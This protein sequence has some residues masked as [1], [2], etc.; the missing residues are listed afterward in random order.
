MS[1]ATKL[2]EMLT[3]QKNKNTLSWKICVL[4]SRLENATRLSSELINS[5]RKK[6]CNSYAKNNV[7]VSAGNSSPVRR[8]I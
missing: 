5:N 7:S 3:P 4:S 1:F 8:P 2:I 6:E